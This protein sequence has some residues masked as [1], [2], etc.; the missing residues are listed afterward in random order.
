MVNSRKKGKSFSSS[1]LKPSRGMLVSEYELR[2]SNS[3]SSTAG[4]EVC[5]GFG[6]ERYDE[7]SFHQ[8]SFAAGSSPLHS[9]ISSHIS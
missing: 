4:K 3:C 9:V 7:S 5:T 2:S 8:P 1:E 6:D